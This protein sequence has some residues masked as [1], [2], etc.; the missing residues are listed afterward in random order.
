MAKQIQLGSHSYTL[1]RKFTMFRRFGITSD[2]FIALSEF[3]V[4][5]EKDG[6]LAFLDVQ[7]CREDDGTI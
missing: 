1:A 5:K 7:L 4:E 2:T 6:Q 3:T